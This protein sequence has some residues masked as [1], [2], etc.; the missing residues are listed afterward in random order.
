MWR[1][2]PIANFLG[3][4]KGFG[5]RSIVG[6]GIE[7]PIGRSVEGGGKN[8][9]DAQGVEICRVLTMAA[10]GFLGRGGFE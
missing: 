10:S 2:D 6:I 7:P 1:L 5:P 4:M 8:P 3:H 9:N